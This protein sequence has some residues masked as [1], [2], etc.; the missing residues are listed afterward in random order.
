MIKAAEI[1]RSE[2]PGLLLWRTARKL[3]RWAFAFN[4]A[5]WLVC[6]LTGDLPAAATRRPEVKVSFHTEIE[7]AAGWI[8][9]L[10]EGWMLDPREYRIARESA[11]TWCLISVD[12]ENAG[13]LKIGRGPAMVLDFERVIEFPPGAAFIYDTYIIPARRGMGLGRILVRAVIEYLQE[14][15]YQWVCCHVPGWNEASY[16]L[17]TSMDF[18]PRRRIRFLKILGLPI[19]SANPAQ[20]TPATGITTRYLHRL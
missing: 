3:G 1:Y 9:S 11:H 15:N 16:R 7:E 13:Y 17:F 6:D 19:L 18:H 14:Q 10:G 20:L 8:R 5:R 4:Q 12:G 2:G